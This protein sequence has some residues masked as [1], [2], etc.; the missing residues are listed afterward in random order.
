MPKNKKKM[1]IFVDDVNMPM[2]EEF[3][4]QPP[5]SCCGSG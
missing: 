4:A 1:V 5:V 2:K 3:G